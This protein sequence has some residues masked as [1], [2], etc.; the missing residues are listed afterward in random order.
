[1]RALICEKCGANLSINDDNRDFAFCQYCGTKIMLDDYRS[2]HT[3]RIIDEARVIEAVTE[4]QIRLREMELQ[5]REQNQREQVQAE[6]LKRQ[7]KI[8]RKIKNWRRFNKILIII[9]IIVSLILLIT[10]LYVGIPVILVGGYITL[11][12]IPHFIDNKRMIMET[13]GIRIPTSLFPCE[14]RNFNEV[15]LTLEGLGFT[16]VSCVNLHDVMIGIIKRQGSVEKITVNGIE[17]QFG[18][19]MYPK[20]AAIVIT[21]HGR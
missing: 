2:S 20:N 12:R 5:E 3:Q 14:D 15:L 18:G 9:W 7:K 11:I 6:E 8:E 19:R 21:Y 10:A 17:V 4:R 16:N 1:M 13:G